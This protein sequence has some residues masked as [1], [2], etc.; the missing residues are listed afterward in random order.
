MKTKFTLI[1]TLAFFC[2][3][4]KAQDLNA[5][6]SEVKKYVKEIK[7]EK[8]SLNQVLESNGANPSELTL[9]VTQ[10][11]SKNKSS[12]EEFK[13]DLI[14]FDIGQVKREDSKKE[15]L[16]ELKTTNGFDAVQY[17]KNGELQKYQDK[18]SIR[19]D[20]A[21]DARELEKHL[22]TAITAAK[23]RF[24]ANLKLPTT[25]TELQKYVESAI[26]SFEGNGISVAQKTIR[27]NL[28]NDRVVIKSK[29]SGA[30]KDEDYSYDFSWGDIAES[31]IEIKAMG[32]AVAI[33]ANTTDK[34]EFIKTLDLS[35]NNTGY[36]K[37]VHFFTATPTDA[38]I[39]ATALQKFIPLARKEMQN[40]IPKSGSL[41]LEV[42]SKISDFQINE[43]QYNQKASENCLCQYT[44]NAVV[45]GK[46]KDENF[47]F[48][49]SDLTGFKIEVKKEF[50]VISAKTIDNLKFVSMTDAKTKRSFDNEIQ[51]FLPDIETAR[52][53]LASLLAISNKCKESIRPENFDWLVAKLKNAEVTD[54]T[55][56]L[57]LQE[58]TNRAK[59]RFTVAKNG[60]KKTTE[61]IYEFNV[62]DLDVTKTKFEVEGQNLALTIDTKNKEKLLKQ[63]EDGKP[64][65][66]N[67]MQFLVNNAE[68]VKKINITLKGMIGNYKLLTEG[69]FVTN[70][71]VYD[72]NSAT[73]KSESDETIKMVGNM[74][75]D[76]QGL[77]IKITGFTDSDGDDKKN[78]ELSKKRA[79]AVKDKLVKTYAIDAS[80]IQTEGKG[81]ANPISSNDTP[82]GKAANRRV[83]FVKL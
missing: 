76:N 27:G 75:Q 52:T 20:N 38:K 54:I 19:V 23:A 50:P 1:F 15:L 4:V 39:L 46:S 24:E 26:K 45:K 41:G 33:V 32:K 43:T 29:I 61:K 83:E 72:T 31:S 81:E 57:S 69:K 63:I 36:E 10:T 21:D 73:I 35:K 11:D 70:S 13:F 74:L 56:T 6:L 71:I 62:Y 3:K 65:F 25:F 14:F 67:E 28:Y 47:L 22:K 34:N 5:S 16:I 68:D 12:S 55:Q 58:P 30:K 77:K 17:L 2:I 40:R 64:T 82:E 80:R 49:L 37:E 66:T 18:I 9:K 48:N 59:W 60:G 44:R 7:L 79:A 78:L 53:L 42:L 51:L 8:S